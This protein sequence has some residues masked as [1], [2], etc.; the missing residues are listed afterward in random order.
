MNP[1]NHKIPIVF[2]IVIL[3]G[4]CE[5]KAVEPVL[6]MEAVYDEE[7]LQEIARL[8]AERNQ[9]RIDDKEREEQ[10]R[11]ERMRAQGVPPHLRPKNLPVIED[12]PADSLDPLLTDFLSEYFQ[13]NDYVLWEPPL[14]AHYRKIH[15]AVH[16]IMEHPRNGK[17]FDKAIGFEITD[18]GIIPYLYLKDLQFINQDGTAFL[19]FTESNGYGYLNITGFMFY[20]SIDKSGVKPSGLGIDTYLDNGNSVADSFSI[21]WNEEK[22]VFESGF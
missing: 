2:L 15:I 6:D 16:Y 10:E 12:I 5:K 13:N 14:D 3:A 17:I 19:D 4:G 1:R 20:Y 9:K 18:E 7:F 22:K 21:D 11:L 8:Q